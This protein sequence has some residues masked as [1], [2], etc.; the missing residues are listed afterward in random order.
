MKRLSAIF[1][2]YAQ[3]ALEYKSRSFVWFLLV[4]IDAFIYLLYWRG[5]LT[6]SDSRIIWTLP[7][8]ISY[9]LLL[10]VASS[11]LQ[12]HI[13]EEMAFEDIQHGRLSQYLTRPFPYIGFK[14]FQELPWRIIQ[15]G[16]GA[17]TLIGI[18][19]FIK[20]IELV[21]DPQAI[22]LVVLIALSAFFLCFILKMIVGSIAFWTIDFS[23]VENISTIAFLLFSG[24]LLPLHLL[25][26]FMRGF[27]LGQPIAYTLYYPV[28]AVQ[29]LFTI[30]ELWRVLF[31]QW[32]W[33]GASYIVFRF[34]WSRGLRQFT[35]VG[36]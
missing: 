35:A 6:G 25:P 4:L 29:G 7:Q 10:L 34:L 5:V 11:L 23:G 27:A 22:P 12:V 31:I 21:S 2:L 8:A 9:Y 36:Q 15:G 3:H 18:S 20:R 19:L 33:I 13:E 1:F 16:F 32:A 30:P 28:L 14:F 26:D 24:I 17:V